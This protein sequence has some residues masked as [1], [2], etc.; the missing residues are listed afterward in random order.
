MDRVGY[1]RLV[2]V[3]P[4][5]LLWAGEA[6][7]TIGDEFFNLAVMWVIYTQSNSVLQTA[8]VQVVW[9]IPDILFA[10][11][12]GAWADRLDRKKIIVVT[13]LLAALAVAV[14]AAVMA[15]VGHLP[16]AAA[17]AAV[18]VLNSL[19]TFL[20]P[21]RA[22]IVPQLVGPAA[23]AS[24]NG[25][26][27]SIKQTASFAGSALAGFAIALFTAVWALVV[28]VLSFLVVAACVWFARLPARTVESARPAGRRFPA[29]AELREAW[30]LMLAHPVVRVTVFLSVLVNIGSM[31]GPLYPALVTGQLQANAAVYGSIGAAAVIG[32]AVGGIAAG[33]M[34]RRIGAGRLMISGW[35]LAGAATAG[36]GLSTSLPLSLGLQAVIVF[37][38]TA[39][40]VAM[41]AV[42]GAL[43]PENFRGRVF[44]LSQSLSVLLIPISA[45]LGGLLADQIGVVPL[46][47]GCG[48]WIAVLS[49]VALTSPHVR[50]VRLDTPESEPDAAK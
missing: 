29:G 31:L 12:A 50:N 22:S 30:R 23:L 38:M 26:F 45:L 20:R 34:E 16:L 47:V 10:P 37:G 28:D 48:I 35:L 4:L 9:Q 24:A 3:R 8:L 13:N 18:F 33:P 6:V 44:G 11:V 27:S 43:V 39:G 46:F 36:I 7:S 2:G 42:T 32:G 14:L 17:L 49:C 5:R 40:G 21:A 1:R 15:A 19:T 41:G 25:V